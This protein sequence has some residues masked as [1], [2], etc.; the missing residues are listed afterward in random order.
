PRPGSGKGRGT[1]G[2]GR[3]IEMGW[4]ILAWVR[5]ADV[6]AG[7]L[8]VLAAGSLAALLCRQPVRRARLV[9]LTLLG[10]VAVPGLAPLPGAPRWSAGLLPAP[11]PLR[12]RPDDGA[13]AVAGVR[14]HPHEAAGPS[15][16]PGLA[17]RPGEASTI[18]SRPDPALAPPGP[19]RPSP[20]L[21]WT[22]PP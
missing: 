17:Q 2:E 16:A 1:M 8:I 22:V 19:A 12:P 3:A 20:G 6:A 5:P 13:S 9:V 7:G 21:R 11:A 4:Q 18:A 10:A 14:L 15:D